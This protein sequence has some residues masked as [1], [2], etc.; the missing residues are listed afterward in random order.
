MSSIV[1]GPYKTSIVFI[2]NEFI[3]EKKKE[4]KCRLYTTYFRYRFTA[5]PRAFTF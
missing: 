2:R 1:Y 4:K 5:L 3:M